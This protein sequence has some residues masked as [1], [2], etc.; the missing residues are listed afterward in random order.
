MMPP[1][2]NQPTPERRSK[3]KALAGF[4]LRQEEICAIIGLRS[5]KTLRRHYRRELAAGVAE[6]TTKVR[7]TAFQLAMSGRDPRSTIFW[8]RTRGCWSRQMDVEERI[9]EEFV[10]EDYQP[11]PSMDQQVHRDLRL[12]VSPKSDHPIDAA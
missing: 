10:M 4:G 2:R 5:P 8:L 1:K 11:P 9:V 7:Q 6:A 12:R 3:V